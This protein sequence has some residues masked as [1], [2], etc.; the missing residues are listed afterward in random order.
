MNKYTVIS[1]CVIIAVCLWWYMWRQRNLR[2]VAQ[3][4]LLK[5][6]GTLDSHAKNALKALD[7]IEQPSAKDKFLTARV[8]ELNGHEGRI[9]NVRTLDDVVGRYM[10]NLADDNE[11]GL[12]WFEIDQ[13]ENFAERHRD[14]MNGNAR[15]ETFQGTVNKKRPEM[16][17]MTIHDAKE[18]AAN[19]AEAFTA[20]ANDTVTYTNDSQNVH[21]SA[22]N[23]Q[24]RKT[25]SKLKETTPSE[26]V[27]AAAQKLSSSIQSQVNSYFTDVNEKTRAEKSLQKILEGRYNATLDANE[28][29]ILT[30]VWARSCMGENFSNKKLI[31][32]A[33]VQALRDMGDE[34]SEGVV[35]SSGRCAR[36]L[37]SL[38]FTDQQDE[39]VAGVMT[40]EQIRN[41]VMER[42]NKLLHSTIDEYATDTLDANGGLAK[43]ARSYI[44]P[45]VVVSPDDEKAFKQVVK[46]KINTLIKNE[47]EDK[48]SSRDVKNIR[49]H[50]LAA[51]DSI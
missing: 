36:L 47:Y 20:Y 33:V 40:T 4:E 42:S 18:K 29:D 8:I 15:Y 27:S 39:A 43:A 24:L 14:I 30:L 1:I 51:I 2:N 9:N 7:Q 46:H 21:D 19:R 23:E 5:S 50:C 3:K 34:D 49:S 25:Y 37:E 17:K 48:L 16:L 38:L 31:R 45:S 28:R 6:N 22:V 12:D 35:C 10:Y 11:F 44:D 41:D 32:D 13:I 26:A